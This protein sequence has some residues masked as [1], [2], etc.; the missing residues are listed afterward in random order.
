MP[1]DNTAEPT[2]SV[3]DAPD[4]RDT[5][6]I[7]TGLANYNVSK[8][9]LPDFKPIAVLATDPETG[10]TIGGLYGRTSF[11]QLFVERFF[12]PEKYRGSGLGSRVLAMAEAEGKRRGC[13]IAALFTLEVQAPGFYLKQGWTMAAKLECPPPGITRYLMTKKL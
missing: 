13:G 11:G 7:A 3:T 1:E 2:I 12:L 4:P 5:G 10:E 8:G 9:G 6:L